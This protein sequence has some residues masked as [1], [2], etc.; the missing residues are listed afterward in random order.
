[1][2]TRGC[3]VK[4]CMYQSDVWRLS[5]PRMRSSRR[6]DSLTRGLLFKLLVYYITVGVSVFRCFWFLLLLFVVVFLK[7]QNSL[8]TVGYIVKEYT[9]SYRKE[10]HVL[11]NDALNT[12]IYG[13]IAKD[14]SVTGETRCR[15]FMGYSF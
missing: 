4:Q 6:I 11:F 10:G 14:H 15:R 1:M 5:T 9:D 2:S 13:Y 12:F 3:G 8:Y 7:E